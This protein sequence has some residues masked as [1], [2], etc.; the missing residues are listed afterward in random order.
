[1][2]ALHVS[3]LDVMSGHPGAGVRAFVD[4][5]SAVEN[6]PV[7]L[8]LYKDGVLVAEK[9]ENAD[10]A[11]GFQVLDFELLGLCLLYTSRCV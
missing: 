9:E 4:A 8:G 10:V 2:K 11:A 7:K 5:A 3:P 6:V 1:M